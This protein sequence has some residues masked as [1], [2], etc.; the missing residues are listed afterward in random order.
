MNVLPQKIYSDGKNGQIFLLSKHL[1]E[2]M[3]FRNKVLTHFLFC[4]DLPFVHL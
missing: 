3:P 4:C 2:I 1:T